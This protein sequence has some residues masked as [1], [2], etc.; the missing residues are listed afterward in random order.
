[1]L[2]IGFVGFSLLWF[3][4]LAGVLHRHLPRRPATL[5]LGGLAL[6][7]LYAATLAYLGVL[8]SAEAPPRVLLLVPPL[9]VFAVWLARARAP[10]GLVRSL[11]LRTLTGLQSFRIGVEIFLH[12]LWQAGLLPVG[13]TWNG[14]NFD[15]VTGLTALVLFLLW[16]RI[17]R[18]EALAWGWNVGGLLL[19]AQVAVTGILS[20]PGPQHLLNKDQPNLA[21]V[22]FPYVLVAAF[23]VLSALALHILSLRKLSS[24]RRGA[25]R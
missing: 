16:D 8:R 9:L 2:A 25:S 5:A 3:A 12:A 17:P 18:V 23:F 22:S 21:I 1:M 13:M 6:W 15:I 20:A 24:L 14:H 7:L 19:L 10:S 11:S 4:V